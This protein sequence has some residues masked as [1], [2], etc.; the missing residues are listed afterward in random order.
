[1]QT[2]AEQADIEPLTAL[3]LEVGLGGRPIGLRWLLTILFWWRG[4][5][6]VLALI[7]LSQHA[8]LTGNRRLGRWAAGTLRRDYGCFVQPGARIGPKLW[9]PHPNGIVIGTGARIGSGCTIYHQV[10]LGGAR[11]GDWQANRYPTVG[12][13]VTIFAGA[14]LIGAISVGDGAVIGA[15]AVVNRDVPPHHVAMGVPARTRPIAAARVMETTV[16]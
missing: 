2:V 6:R 9:L 14:K 11:M 7:R 13:N 8:H 15:N 3:S 4:K 16:D 5:K 12:N 10:T 1:M